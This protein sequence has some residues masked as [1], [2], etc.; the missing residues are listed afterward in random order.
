MAMPGWFCQ[1]VIFI[2]YETQHYMV[3]YL[4]SKVAKLYS[5]A[6]SSTSST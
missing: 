5:N 6:C 1:N 2:N 3:S 4:T